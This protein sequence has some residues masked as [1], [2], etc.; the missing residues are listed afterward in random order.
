MTISFSNKAIGH[1]LEAVTDSDVWM[2]V[3]PQVFESFV[4]P[5]GNVYA[6]VR[7]PINRE[8]VKIDASGSL[9]ENLKVT[10]GQ[11]GTTANAWPMGALLFNSTNEDHYNAIIQL[12]ESRV[13]DYNPNEIL[14]PLY[15]GEKVYQNGPAG[16]ERWWISFNAVNPYWDIFTGAP[17]GAE[18]YEDIGWTYDLLILGDPW[19]EKQT[20]EDPGTSV[21][22]IYSM[23]Y[24]SSRHY[25]FAGV[26]YGG[27]IFRSE[28]GGDTWTL[29][30]E[31]TNDR[32]RS[33]VYDAYH[34]TLI[35][36]TGIVG[37][38]LVSPNGGGVWM[39]SDY[40][41]Q[42]ITTLCYAPDTHTLIAGTYTSAKIYRSTDGGYNWTFIQ[43]LGIA[44]PYEAYVSA[45]VYDPSRSR[46]ICGTGLDDGSLWVSTDD[47]IEWVKKKALGDEANP[48]GRI[49]SMCYDIEHDAII[50]GTYNDAQLW[51]SQ[52]GG[53][54]WSLIKDLNLENPGQ[55]SIDSLVY[56]PDNHWVFA[57]S[58][59]DCQ[60]WI[61]KDGGDTWAMEQ[62]LEQTQIWAM[63]YDSY[64]GKLAAG[65][66]SN[67]GPAVIW[68]RGNT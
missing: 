2:K 44:A 11:G 12:G 31:T 56:N 43:N 10:R 54:T 19:S 47:G 5:G 41:N 8:I 61:S 55:Y 15:A 57:G 38:V 4:R 37:E 46:F 36:G 14:A 27:L 17:C 67:F 45:L 29:N 3:S 39:P 60:I 33:L 9:N 68:T 22:W 30:K 28:D 40:I 34:D 20:L 53:E 21:K 26:K 49:Y 35:A 66:A 62:S 58:A 25:L 23:C 1:L 18:F 7:G 63:A 64:H 51:R 16:C 13:I 32:I 50:C 65:A 42:E 48:Q 52:N 24:D 6:L 59:Y